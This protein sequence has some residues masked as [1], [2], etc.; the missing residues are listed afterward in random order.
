MELFQN[1]IFENSVNLVLDQRDDI[2]KSFC[3]ELFWIVFWRNISFGRIP[4]LYFWN[5]HQWMNCLKIELFQNCIFEIS[6]YEVLDQDDFCNLSAMNFL[7]ML[8]K[9]IKKFWNC[10]KTIFWNV[11]QGS[12]WIKE[13]RYGLFKMFSE[14]KK[15]NCSET[16]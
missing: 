13:I 6:V 16:T 3:S 2:L 15:I 12:F 9:K 8:T 10:L 4:N 1:C 5:L 14:G 11:Y 7:K